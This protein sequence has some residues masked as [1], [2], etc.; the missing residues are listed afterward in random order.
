MSET[1]ILAL[2]ITDRIKE[3]GMVQHILS[4]HASLIRSRLGFHEV[5]DEVCSRNGIIILILTGNP[6]KWD[7]FESALSAVQGVE[8]QHMSF[9]QEMVNV[10]N[11]G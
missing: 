8:V 11:C 3:S 5:S 4:K 10:S 2:M 1:R 9:R 6:T 7:E